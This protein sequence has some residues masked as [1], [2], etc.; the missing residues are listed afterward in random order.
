ML[1]KLSLAGVIASVMLLFGCN[2]EFNE[3]SPTYAIPFVNSSLSVY[4]LLA[5]VDSSRITTDQD[6]L[7]TLIYKNELLQLPAVTILPLPNQNI[8]Q[9]IAY[10]GPTLNPFPNGQSTTVAGTLDMDFSSLGPTEIYQILFERGKLLM[11][12]SSTMKQDISYKLTFPDLKFSGVAAVLTG[13]SNYTGQNH[14]FR[15]S[16]ML[17]GGNADL[18]LNNTTFNKFRMN[19]ELTINGTGNALSNGEK[20][21]FDVNFIG[22][23]FNTVHCYLGQIEVPLAQD[24]MPLNLFQ[25]TSESQTKP[26]KFKLTDPKLFLTFSNNMV[27]PLN[28]NLKKLALK[29]ESNIETNFLLTGFTNPFSLD[30]PLIPGT[31]KSKTL[32]FTK[33][34]SNIKDILE[35]D[36]KALIYQVS[37]LPNPD[38]K[39]VNI[40]H[41]DGRIKVDANVE[42]PMAG[43][44]ED[45]ILSD[46]VEL[47]LELGEQQ[48]FK[49]GLVRFNCDNSFPMDVF[50]QVYF[51][52]DAK[53]VVD[54][55]FGGNENFLNSAPVDANGRVTATTHASKDIPADN[56]KMASLTKSKY[57]AIFARLNTFQANQQREIKVYKDYHIDVKI[58]LKAEVGYNINK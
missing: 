20:I 5:K 11:S 33:T 19:Y 14:N 50:V 6:G 12:I 25:F 37:A 38:G 58:G 56:K 32:S 35:P 28:I 39:T 26:G 42:L 24:S 15:D 23:V 17:A 1:R 44:G 36:Q 13:N 49:S 48:E 41:K 40:I 47:G 34:N 9:D 10:N 7:V 22:T 52:N 29:K 8:K 53:Q 21:S 2:Y 43:Y 57:V 3:L 30:Y 31:D 4:N 45:W 27:L 46:T 51:L 18:T 16:V 54:S 55:L